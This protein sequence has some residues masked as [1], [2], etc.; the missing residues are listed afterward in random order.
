MT[1]KI[2]VAHHKEGFI[3]KDNLHEPIHV[4]KEL[5]N[6]NLGILGDNSHQNIS[7]LN[8]L[9]C[10]LTATYWA[11]KNVTTDYIGIC[12]YRRYFFNRKDLK[13]TLRNK[14][15]HLYH[16]LKS[17]V[18]KNYQGTFFFNQVIVN[19]IEKEK[20]LKE[21]SLWLE[22]HI[23]SNDIDIYALKPVQHLKKTNFD[24]F[25]ILGLEY[26]EQLKMIVKVNFPEYYESL[27]STLNSNR[28]HYANMIVMKHDFFNEYCEFVFE[29]LSKHVASNK[30]KIEENDSYSRIPGYM[31]ELLTN[32]FILYKQSQGLKMK[33]LKTMLIE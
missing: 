20:L 7:H 13:I 2:L 8:P 22:N 23:N 33:F 21:F 3:Y 30:Q 14:I 24:F 11:W 31:A 25:S 17:I 10:E 26:L 12:H 15:S 19:N 6:I 28:L 5:S 32:T 27:N 16:Y 29:V 1:I 4:G 18:L 9:Y